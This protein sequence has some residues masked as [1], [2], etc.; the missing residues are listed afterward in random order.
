MRIGASRDLPAGVFP[1]GSW[2]L[3]GAGV[4]SF[5]ASTLVGGT[6]VGKVGEEGDSS[7]GMRM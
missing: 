3:M 2:G 5:L 6:G 7:P 1:L 4:G